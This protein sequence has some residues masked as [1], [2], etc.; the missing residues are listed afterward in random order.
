MS[1]S[2]ERWV[3]KVTDEWL[4]KL[5]GPHKFR[6][7]YICKFIRLADLQQMWYSADEE[8]IPNCNLRIWDKRTLKTFHIHILYI[9]LFILLL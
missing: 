9:Y 1:L 8:Q 7:S 2:L 4:T 3:A 5:G 6:E